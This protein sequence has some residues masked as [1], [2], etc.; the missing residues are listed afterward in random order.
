MA[1]QSVTEK[2]AAH[3]PGPWVFEPGPHGDPDFE[4]IAFL[5]A[6]QRPGGEAIGIIC[7]PVMSGDVEANARLIA[8]APDLLEALKAL[9]RNV[10]M[11]LCGFWKESTSNFM[12]QA[13]AAIA[14]AEGVSDV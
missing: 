12:Q 2:K 6:E 13:E 8:A 11:D 5:I 10:D 14:K 3:T 7:S 9:H 4:D 1:E